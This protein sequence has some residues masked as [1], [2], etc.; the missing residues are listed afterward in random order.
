MFSMPSGCS[1]PCACARLDISGLRPVTG[2][3]AWRSTGLR[4][5]FS[6]ISAIINRAI[7]VEKTTGRPNVSGSLASR[8]SGLANDQ[9]SQYQPQFQQRNVM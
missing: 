3:A 5:S 9:T 8:L 6:V 1:W 4:D 7:V 2:R